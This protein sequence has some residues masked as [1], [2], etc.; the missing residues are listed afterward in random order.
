MFD[1]KLHQIGFDL[2]FNVAP[3]DW[4]IFLIMSKPSQN[5]KSTL[6]VVGF[7]IIL[8]SHHRNTPDKNSTL[9]LETYQARPN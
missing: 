7:D 2:V 8:T 4:K 1:Q 9:A 3:S 6:V 5:I